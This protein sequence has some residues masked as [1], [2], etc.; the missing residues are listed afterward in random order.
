MNFEENSC[1]KPNRHTTVTATKTVPIG[2]VSARLRAMYEDL[3]NE[4]VPTRLLDIVQR[5]DRTADPQ[6]RRGDLRHGTEN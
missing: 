3:C 1:S 4:P 2:F 5:F 6:P